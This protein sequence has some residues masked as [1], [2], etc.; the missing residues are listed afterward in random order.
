MVKVHTIE[1]LEHS[2]KNFPN[3]KAHTDMI[4]GAIV[5]MNPGITTDPS[6]GKPI[7]VV[8]NQQVGDNEYE[9]EYLIS[10]DSMTNLYALSSWIDKELD[11]TESNIQYGSNETYSDLAVGTELTFDTI[12]FKFKKGTATAGDINFIITKRWG[13]LVNGITVKIGLKDSTSN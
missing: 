4:N 6:T 8:L 11:I 10:K 3:I 1:M 13:N 12:T 9:D 7:Y 5:G 2:A